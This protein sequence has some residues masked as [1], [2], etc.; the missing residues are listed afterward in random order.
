M[1]AERFLLAVAHW[2]L[3]AL[4]YFYMD[5]M[6]LRSVTEF[7][8]VAAIVLFAVEMC[9]LAFRNTEVQKEK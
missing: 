2:F 4:L 5:R 1:N 3:G 7:T 6:P 9:I 8:G